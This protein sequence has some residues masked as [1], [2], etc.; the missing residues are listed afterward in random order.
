MTFWLF[1]PNGYEAMAALDDDGDSQLRGHELQHV[2]IWRDTNQN[3]I[4]EAGEVRPLSVYRIV[5]LSCMYE[6]GDGVSVVG[7]SPAGVTFADG[8]TRATYDVIL[9]AVG[10]PIRLS[11]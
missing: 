11:E 8:T 9:R 3:G 5:A 10:P 6:A 7:H 2:A 1:W 4:S